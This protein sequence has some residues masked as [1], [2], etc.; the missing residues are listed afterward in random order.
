MR[1]PFSLQHEWNLFWKRIPSNEKT[2]NFIQCNSPKE[3]K[4]LHALARVG[5]IGGRQLFHL[6][7]IDKKR[8]KK[9]VR[10]QKIVRHEM[11][12][13]NKIIPIYTLGQTGAVIT[14][15]TAYEVNYWVE[16]RIEDVLKRLLFFK[17][18]QYFPGSKVLPTPEPFVGAIRFGKNVFYIYVVRGDTTD[19]MNYLKWQGHKFNGRLILIAENLKHVQPIL[20][21]TD[22][23]MLRLTTDQDL[24]SSNDL[25]E[26]FYFINDNGEMMKEAQ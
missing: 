2:M 19:L 10:E 25:K 8:L 14:N 15:H 20:M 26:L 13:K 24:I 18:Y 22:N 12:L 17:L 11:K 9:M 1:S 4:A 6:F 7:S 16:Y 23:I 21:H 5:V 3:Q